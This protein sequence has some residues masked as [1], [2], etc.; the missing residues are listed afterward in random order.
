MQDGGH[1]GGVF[2][3]L[4]SLGE[5][6]E[7]RLEPVVIENGAAQDALVG[8]LGATGLFSECFLAALEVN[9][10]SHRPCPTDLGRITC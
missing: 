10:G 1:R 4:L 9:D 2:R 5:A 3:K 7:D 8:W 6:K